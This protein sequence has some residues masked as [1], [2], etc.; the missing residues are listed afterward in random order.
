LRHE[1]RAFELQVTDGSLECTDR[2]SREWKDGRVEDGGVLS[3]QKSDVGDI[4]RAN[5]VGFRVDSSDNLGGCLFLLVDDVDR[6]E[7]ADDSNARDA[8][9]LDLSSLAFDFLSVKLRD[10]AAIDFQTSSDNAAIA[11]YDPAK[12]WRPVDADWYV[13]RKGPAEPDHADLRKAGTVTFHDRVDKVRGSDRHARDLPRVDFRL[14]EHRFDDIVDPIVGVL[15]RAGLL[16]GDDSS[17][18]V[19]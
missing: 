4:F 2:P 6:A 8:L 18:D 3:L 13:F 7:D 9:G 10:Q 12:L 5:D 15:R 16:P 11:T 1:D 17:V 14:F 19:G